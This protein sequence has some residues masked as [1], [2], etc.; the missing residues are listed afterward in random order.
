MAGRAAGQQHHQPEGR[1]QP[2]QDCNLAALRRAEIE[3]AENGFGLDCCA[4]PDRDVLDKISQFLRAVTGSAVLEI[5]QAHSLAVPQQVGQVAVA[6]AEYG[7][8]AGP[9]DLGCPG[10]V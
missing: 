2:A 8:A 3:T 10:A 9:G 7:S 5:D 4:R 6:E 1:E